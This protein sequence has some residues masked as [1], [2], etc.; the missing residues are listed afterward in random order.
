MH[1][2]LQIEPMYD[3]LL[4]T[5]FVVFLL[6]LLLMV[7]QLFDDVLLSIHVIAT[8]MSLVAATMTID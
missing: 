4:Y 5:K 1:V 3:F 6:V 7:V 2:V 8:M